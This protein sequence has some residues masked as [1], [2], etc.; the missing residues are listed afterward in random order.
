MEMLLHLFLLKT[1]PNKKH[2][3]NHFFLIVS[4]RNSKLR[5]VKHPPRLRMR[6]KGGS[7][8]DAGARDI[9]PTPRDEDMTPSDTTIVYKISSFLYLHSDFWYNSFGSTC[10]CRYLN[11]GT[12]VS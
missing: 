12:N 8:T 10:T 5:H 7:T 1:L 6:S 9:T 3:S 4:K 11:V 2:K